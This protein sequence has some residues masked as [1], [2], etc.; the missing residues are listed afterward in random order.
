MDPI[1]CFTNSIDPRI[2]CC[3]I[4]KLDYI[5]K[6]SNFDPGVGLLAHA[7]LR[8]RVNQAENTKV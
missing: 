3:A 5:D 8:I 6:K 4:H 1:S 7:K 2:E